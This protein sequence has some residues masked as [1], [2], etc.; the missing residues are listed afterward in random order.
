MNGLTRAGDFYLATLQVL[1][2][3]AQQNLAVQQALKVNLTN[4]ALKPSPSALT[5]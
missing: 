4:V 3:F 5:L 2:Q 1:P